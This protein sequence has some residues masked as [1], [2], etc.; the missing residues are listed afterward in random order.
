ML[1]DDCTAT[2]GELARAGDDWPKRA[3]EAA[4]LLSGSVQDDEFVR[5]ER[6]RDLGIDADDTGQ[7]AEADLRTQKNGC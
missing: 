3:R 4:T 1:A 7:L 6:L 2:R 5:R